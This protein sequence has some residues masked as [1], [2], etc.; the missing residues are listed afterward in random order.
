TT[1]T[2]GM[3]S[4]PQGPRSTATLLRARWN[5]FQLRRRYDTKIRKFVLELGE[6]LFQAFEWLCRRAHISFAQAFQPQGQIVGLCGSVQSH[7][8]LEGVRH[9]PQLRGVALRDGL[10][11]FAKEL[12]RLAEKDACHIRQK[13]FVSI[14]GLEPSG[15]RTVLGCGLRGADLR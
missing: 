11:D 1:R 15:K 2:V 8:S 13:A 9:P 14:D 10:V 4:S 5:G 3:R 12:R 6:G 7:P